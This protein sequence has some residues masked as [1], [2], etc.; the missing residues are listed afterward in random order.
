VLLSEMMPKCKLDSER[1]VAISGALSFSRAICPH[2]R[3]IKEL[4]T[5]L[6]SGPLLADLAG[7]LVGSGGTFLCRY[8]VESD[9]DRISIVI[10][11]FLVLVIFDLWSVWH[12]FFRVLPL[13][14]PQA[15]SSTSLFALRRVQP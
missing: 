4:S 13:V 12:G 15:S 7:T 10:V 5:E 1:V 8:G 6:G 9:L 2:A 11:L 3:P 14:V